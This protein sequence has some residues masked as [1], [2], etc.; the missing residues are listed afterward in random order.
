MPLNRFSTKVFIYSVDENSQFS[1]E[2]V[3]IMYDKLGKKREKVLD[4]EQGISKKKVVDKKKCIYESVY[5]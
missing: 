1:N 2:C 5:C 4:F 3:W